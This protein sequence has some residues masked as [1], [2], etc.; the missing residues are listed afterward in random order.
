MRE[1]HE[2]E[3]AAQRGYTRL[4]RVNEVLREVLADELERVNDERLELVT[5][6]GVRADRDF[7]HARVWFDT[8]GSR[9]EVAEA[10][11]EYRVRL[12]AAVGR[13]LRLKHTPEL[14]FDPDPA[15]ATG[16]RVEE[17]LRELH[18]AGTQ[19]GPTSEDGTH[20]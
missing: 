11:A 10:L 14:S 18:Q 4:D 2:D 12:Q 8:L 19:P 7:R 13:Q 6:T 1:R 9:E 3:M 17:I 5:V 15:I 20:D 16:T